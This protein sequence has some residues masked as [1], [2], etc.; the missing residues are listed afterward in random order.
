MAGTIEPGKG[1]KGGKERIRM[2][3]LLG[4]SIALV[5]TGLVLVR[6]YEVKQIY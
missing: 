5:V 1:P 4:V 3:I 2:V 6:Y